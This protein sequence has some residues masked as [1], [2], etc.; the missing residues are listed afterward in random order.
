M[1]AFFASNS[2]KAD[3]LMH[4]KGLTSDTDSYQWCQCL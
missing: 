2:V 1:L 3:K 4:D